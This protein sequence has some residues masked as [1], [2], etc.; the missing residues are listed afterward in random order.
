MGIS[1]P[2]AM[3]HGSLE[4]VWYSIVDIPVV[5]S[6]W[7]DVVL[8]RNFLRITLIPLWCILEAGGFIERCGD[9]GFNEC[10]LFKWEVWDY[11]QGES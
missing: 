5:G 9:F 10:S 1:L 4:V 6:Y 7:S 3:R 2:A 8:G 11:F